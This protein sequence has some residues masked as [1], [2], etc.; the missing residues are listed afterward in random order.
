[1][2]GRIPD[3]ILE[4]IRERSSIVEVVSAHV[5]LKKAG[6]GFS[7]LCPFH[8][9][10]TPSFTVNEERG[11][12]HCFGC[13][14]GGTVF[15]FLMKVEGLDFRGAVEQLA[16]RAGVRLPEEDAGAGPG[17]DER[18]RLFR[19]NEAAQRRWVDSLRAAE[20]AEAR[21][22][23]ERRGIGA[24]VV[25]RYGLGF[26]PAN[27]SSF[28]RA[29]GGRRQAVDAALAIGLL[30]RRDDGR[31]YERQWGRITFPIRDGTGRI[32]GFG[33]RALG[34]RQ[35]KYLNSPESPLFHK[36]SV[37]YGLYEARAAIREADT[38]VMVEGYMDAIALAQA[39]I[40]NVVA[41]LGTALTEEQLRLARRFAAQVV[42]FFDGDRAGQAAAV[43]A[44]EV[45]AR[46]G[47]WVSGAFLP[48]GEDPDSFVR[49]RGAEATRALLGAAVALEDFFFDSISPGPGTP[50]AQRA[51]A[52]QRA[53]EVLAVVAD[54]VRFSLLA[55]RAAEKLG[56]DEALFRE[57]RA[58]GRR[59]AARQVRRDEAAA[60]GVPAPPPAPNL[61]VEEMV[62]LEVMALDRGACGVAVEAEAVERLLGPAAAALAGAILDAWDDQG[63]AAAVIDRLPADLHAR[64]SAGLLGEGPFVG[65][66]RAEVARDCVRALHERW[67]GARI[68]RLKRE[69]EQAQKAGDEARSRT[70]DG[71]I[72]ALLRQRAAAAREGSQ[73]KGVA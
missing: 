13:G 2:A 46:A 54:P 73:E 18:S 65:V 29:L 39:G 69:R 11:L 4:T 70:L 64:V 14:E 62:L 56:V 59:P 9:E 52:V 8:A 43:R 58:G 63:S 27:G 35:P 57:L 30:G 36:G 42:V 12:Y 60:P 55:R 66:D 3:D 67:I 45:A 33:G 16:Q 1:M 20:G 72:S 41:N 26:C 37:L 61:T 40:G 48:D 38:I 31:V 47:V 32:V 34:D 5:A 50:P 6:R 23:L 49:G 22:Y 24:E 7:G 68:R 15:T 28:L 17:R 53:G 10:K 25:E 44:F 51:A 21:A 71:E 19:L